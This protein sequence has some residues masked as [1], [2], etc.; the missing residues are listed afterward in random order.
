MWYKTIYKNFL[1]VCFV[2]FN[3]VSEFTCQILYLEE[4]IKNKTL[5]SICDSALFIFEN[6]LPVDIQNFEKLLLFF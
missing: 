6:D 3:S 5:W 1:N 4:I 2:F